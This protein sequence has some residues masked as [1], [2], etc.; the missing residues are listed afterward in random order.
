MCQRSQ[1]LP[2]IELPQSGAVLESSEPYWKR[3]E[4]MQKRWRRCG[5]EVKSHKDRIRQIYNNKQIEMKSRAAELHPSHCIFQETGIIFWALPASRYSL[6]CTS[7]IVATSFLSFFSPVFTLT[8]KSYN[9]K[10]LQ[11][12]KEFYWIQCV[13]FFGHWSWLNWPLGCGDKLQF[14]YKAAA[15]IINI[16]TSYTNDILYR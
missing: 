3:R 10:W 4:I 8:L 11:H 5:K 7:I 15:Y 6:G 14:R 1:L 13:S 9:V 2:N 12:W 16:C